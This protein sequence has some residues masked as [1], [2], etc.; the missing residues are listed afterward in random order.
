M[1]PLAAM[2][3]NIRH[4]EQSI[5]NRVERDLF[6]FFL[7]TEEDFKNHAEKINPTLL[8][9]GQRVMEAIT[10]VMNSYAD[11][12]NI[13]DKL[14]AK[15]RGNQRVLQFL[16]ATQAELQ[17]LVGVHF[18]SDYSF[19]RLG[20][21][22]RYLKA[23]SIRAERGSLNV[24]AAESRLQDIAVYTKKYTD[25]HNG[26]TLQ[27]SPEKREKIEELRWMIEE[28]KISLFAQELKTRYRVSPKRLDQLTNEINNI[29][30]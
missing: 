26:L 21:I 5:I 10:P 23:L 20:D 6:A 17:A 7:R 27:A 24:A 18:P 16:T 3:G 19:D 9:Y 29:I 12:R 22:P 13:L 25:L 11:T 8:Q 15:N 4:L 30:Y 2:I 14:A 1:K 28:Y